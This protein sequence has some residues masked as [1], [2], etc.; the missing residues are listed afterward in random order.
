MLLKIALLLSMLS[1]LG[2]TII[3]ISLIRRTRY[4]ISWILIS[5]GF[6]LMA[7]RRL[8]EFSTLFWETPFLPKEEI[9]SWLGILISLLILIGVFFI[10]EIFNLQDRIN[11]IRK[12]SESRVLSAI[13]QTEEK[14]RQNFARDLHDGLGPVLSTIKMTMSA[15]IPEN[16]DP[17]NRTIIQRVARATDEAIISLKEISNQL[18]PHLLKNYGLTSAIET[19]AGRLLNNTSI[20]FEMKSN[21]TE[22]RFSY[23][24]EISLYRII[25]ELMNNSLKH[26]E[27]SNINL[28]INTDKQL[29]HI[30]YSDDGKG[31]DASGFLTGEPQQGQGLENIRSRVKSLNGSFNLKSDRGAGF[32]IQIEI[33]AV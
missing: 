7:I 24:I 12:N 6:V 17:V 13:I 15:I 19:F 21:A 20:L 10:R 8:F 23:N 26:G 27:P 14:S 22:K 29:I 16:L 31:F 32:S 11:Q 9:N 4:N 1:Q 2:A 28:F 3:A 5:T 25:T 33:P 18:S 30:H